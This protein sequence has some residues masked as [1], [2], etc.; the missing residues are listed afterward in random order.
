[1]SGKANRNRGHSFELFIGRFLESV[2]AGVKLVSSRSESRRADN[3][4]ID[5]VPIEGDLPFYVQCK[6]TANS[7]NY[8]ELVGNP[9]RTDKPLVVFHRKTERAGSKMMSR[10]DYVIMDMKTFEAL[11]T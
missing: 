6:A 11:C 2:F 8:H 9:K 5:L 3:D 4:G 7:P 10:G 1:M